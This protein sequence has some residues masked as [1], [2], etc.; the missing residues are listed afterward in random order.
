S[1]DRGGYDDLPEDAGA[2]H[3]I[4][5]SDRARDIWRRRRETA[6]A[7][8]TRL[9]TPRTVGQHHA[10]GRGAGLMML[11]ILCAFRAEVK[12]RSTSCSRHRSRVRDR[13]APGTTCHG[14]LLTRAVVIPVALADIAIMRVLSRR[15]RH[16]LLAHQLA[17]STEAFE[18]GL[19]PGPKLQRPLKRSARLRLLTELDV[20]PPDAYLELDIARRRRARTGERRQ[21]VAIAADV[22]EAPC[23]LRSQRRRFHRFVAEER[24]RPP[25]RLLERRQSE[26]VLAQLE[27]GRPQTIQGIGVVRITIQRRP[28]R[29][30]REV[31]SLEPNPTPPQAVVQAFPGRL[32]TERALERDDRAPEVTDEVLG[33]GEKGSRL[34]VVRIQD[35]G[36][37]QK[38]SRLA[39]LARLEKGPALVEGR[40]C[41]HAPA[42]ILEE[43]RRCRRERGRRRARRGAIGSL[44]RRLPRALGRVPRAE[45]R[46]AR[47]AIGVGLGR[48]R[49]TRCL[50][51]GL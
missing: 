20:A 43:A 41:P 23:H 11:P 30:D 1:G 19:V 14:A 15:G 24:P 36:F 13:E 25:E 46:E 2:A 22:V 37:A 32:A 35:D 10:Q 5:A 4:A 12:V 48:G 34:V 9:T 33:P 50:C 45:R 40:L 27:V 47:E 49:E 42:R 17:R 51:G 18:R 3:E 7:S 26:V 44:L 6:R 29:G 16:V 8:T 39:E 28:E 21:R 31:I 38:V